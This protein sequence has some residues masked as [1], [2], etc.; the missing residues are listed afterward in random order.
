MKTYLNG[1]WAIRVALGLSAVTLFAASPASAQDAPTTVPAPI[2][3]SVVP[4][5]RNPHGT[6]LSI[7]ADV[8]PGSYAF[9]V[10]GVQAINGDLSAD[11]FLIRA[12]FTFGQYDEGI[13]RDVPFEAGSLMVGYQH[14]FDRTRVA[15]FVGGDIIHNGE[16]ADPSVR[17]T[18]EAFRVVGEISTPVTERLDLTGWGSYSTFENQYYVQARALYRPGD[19]GFRMG[20]EGS[21]L[22]GDTWDQ[23][24]LGGHA[25]FPLRLGGLFGELGLSAGY[26]WGQRRVDED[27]LY[28]NAILSISF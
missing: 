26:A 1:P 25:D 17:G 20:P 21:L 23:A 27:G 16:G 8:G 4:S 19:N 2:P 14:A 13:L 7:G 9:Y 6:G 28:A 24:R 10:G 11:G 15:L 18:E 22:G 12:G 3:L 5:E